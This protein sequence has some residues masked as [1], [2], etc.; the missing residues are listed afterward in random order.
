MPT[1]NEALRDAGVSHAVDLEQYG[2]GVVR[3]MVAILN[4]TDADLF[5]AL[6][7]AMDRLPAESFTVER[8][9]SLLFSIR[10]LNREAYEKIERELTPELR[11][12]AG[13][14]AGFQQQLFE[15][16]VPAQ[17]QVRIA[18]APLNVEQV[19]AA[20]MARPFQGVLLREALAGL[21]DGRAK[22][23]RDAVRIGYI[24]NEPLA[25][26]VRR[27]RG[28]RANG[29]ADGL[30]EAPRR[31]VETIVRSAVSHT[32]GFAR[33]RFIEANA[34][35]VEAV[36]WCSVIDARTSSPCFLRDLLKY[37]NGQQH[38]P[39]GHSYPWGAGPGRLHWN[40]RSTSIP[41]VKSWKSLGIDIEEM[42]S[43]TRASL[44]GQIAA[45]TTY[46]SWL[47][48][49]SAARQDEV[50]GPVRGKLFRD[51]G[52]TLDRFATDK[53][54]W[55]TLEELAA[56]DAKAFAKAGVKP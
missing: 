45:Q 1:V 42:D 30:M 38:K 27:I 8:L 10:L 7:A 51:G 29:Y 16:V 18:I 15:S 40:C 2:N 20:A 32:A 43:G 46:G 47:T 36:Q 37:T 5:A 3:R 19:Y 28:T 4:R 17:V 14:E 12:L 52:L 11:N 44:D 6:T 13:Y 48:R 21:E 39:I 55:L 56:R 41:V 34:D 31:H 24:S 35:L 49:Q 26:I 53:G 54:R 23:I 50:L 9:E 33:D 22:V 25:Q